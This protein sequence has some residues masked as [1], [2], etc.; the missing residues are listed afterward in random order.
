MIYQR[1]VHGLRNERRNIERAKSGR[2][3]PSDLEDRMKPNK[4]QTKLSGGQRQPPPSSVRHCPRPLVNILRL[5]WPDE[6]TATW[7][8]GRPQMKIMALF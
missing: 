8:S 3:A 6:P 2:C 4:A 1:T 7:D 5:S